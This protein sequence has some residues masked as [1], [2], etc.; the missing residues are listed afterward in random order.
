MKQ[1]GTSLIACTAVLLLGW[2]ILYNFFWTQ[3]KQRIVSE[4]VAT[5]SD[6]TFLEQIITDAITK[7]KY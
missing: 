6:H 2:F 4:T 5:L 1:F 7:K 3:F